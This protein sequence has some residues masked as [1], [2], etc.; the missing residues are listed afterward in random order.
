MSLVSCLNMFN[1]TDSFIESDGRI[2]FRSNGYSGITRGVIVETLG[3]N[4]VRWKNL[5]EIWN[6]N[7]DKDAF[8]TYIREET[9]AY[10]ETE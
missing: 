6:L 9:L 2:E 7:A 8:Q 4:Q 10:L 5:E 1:R 3:G